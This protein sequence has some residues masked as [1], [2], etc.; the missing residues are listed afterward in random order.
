M[1]FLLRLLLIFWG[2]FGTLHISLAQ[3]ISGIIRDKETGERIAFANIVFLRADGEAVD[4][5]SS[6]IEGRFSKKLAEGSIVRALRV[7]VVGYETQTI[8]I[9]TEKTLF[10]ELVVKKASRELAELVIYAGENPAHPIIKKAVANKPIHDPDKIPEYAH[11]VYNKFI[12]TVS[13][14]AA[15]EQAISDYA[16]KS[17]YLTDSLAIAKDTANTK[18]EKIKA[19]FSQKHLF[20]S[21]AISERKFRAPAKVKETILASRIS[22]FQNPLFSVLATDLQPFGFYSD[23]ITLFNKDYLNPLTRNSTARY[24]FILEDSTIVNQDT[25]YLISFEPAK[26]VRFEGLKGVLGISKSDYAVQQLIA[27]TYDS[28]AMVALRFR[29]LYERQANGRWFPVQLNTLVTLKGQTIGKNNNLIGIGSAYLSD[30]QI[31]EGAAPA[32]IFNHLSSETVADA[33]K[34]DAGYWQSVRPFDLSAL[35]QNTYTF[36]DSVLRKTGLETFANVALALGTDALPV[37]KFTLIP[38]KMLRI[39][40]FEGARFGLGIE[41]GSAI[42]KVAS[43]GAYAGWGT[44]DNALKYGG[45]LRFDLNANRGIYASLMY[46]QDL[47]EAGQITFG[48]PWQR[49]S[50]STSTVRSVLGIVMDSVREL[51][52]DFGL[53]PSRRNLITT[54]SMTLQQVQPTYDY[55][56]I[57][58]ANDGTKREQTDFR[59]AEATADLLFFAKENNIQ[60]MG[61]TVFSRHAFPVFKLRLT[62]G[63]D[64]L[65]GG[66][67]YQKID[68]SFEQ[69]LRIRSLGRTQIRLDAGMV[70]GQVPLMKMYF[71]AG[72]DAVNSRLVYINNAF[73]T[74][75][76][77]EF[78]ADRFAA[79]FF[80][81]HFGPIYRGWR[82]A[83]PSPS[84]VHSMAWGTMSRP[85]D[86]AGISFQVPTQG[87]FEG[88]IVVNHILRVVCGKA[89]WLGLGAGVFQR[90][91][92]HSAVEA[93]QNRTFRVLLKFDF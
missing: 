50:L 52:L 30:I 2:L 10:Y 38:S 57:R 55:R 47:F 78:A 4:G 81:H 33:G 59:F 58:T 85:D 82:Y 32:S 18:S 86:H 83:R 64:M 6:D 90:Y 37:G 23:F 25:I 27:E 80:E 69:M 91:G 73:Q 13:G 89:L 65:G 46:R 45:W 24:H 87:L 29:Q 71:M 1:T 7:S 41:T 49:Q 9:D 51:R 75:G 42:S 70:N 72:G 35:E 19:A 16:L 62:Q 92:P 88:G 48:S 36:M 20:M 31:G 79:L 40:R 93:A 15:A 77:N 61:R 5:T 26:G 76:I 17:S 60:M 43:M 68:L 53:R 22:G 3:T 56:F 34:R 28:T 74:V 44:R 12:I 84:I 11:K 8:S 54:F 63:M 39:N 14:T 21:E 67:D 66:F